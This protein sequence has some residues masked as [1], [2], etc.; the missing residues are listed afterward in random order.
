[1]AVELIILAPFGVAACLI[2]AAVII[3]MRIQQQWADLSEQ[4]DEIMAERVRLERMREGVIER[5]RAL[6]EK[7]AE[8]M[9]GLEI[10]GDN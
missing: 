3:R 8:Y 4:V 1:M 10:Q 5:E 6:Q 7:M 2:V 9:A